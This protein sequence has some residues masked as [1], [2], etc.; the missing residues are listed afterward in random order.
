MSK[1]RFA[2]LG[3][4]FW[5]HFQ[6]PAWFEVGGVELVAAYNRTVAKAEAVAKKFGIPRVY[7]DPEE[8]LRNEKLDFID[9]ITEVPVHEPLVLLAAKYKVPV[10]CQKPMA[11]NY[12]SALRMVEACKSAGVP[13]FVHENYRWQAPMRRIKQMVNEGKI[14]RLYRG[15]FQFVHA[16]PEFAWQNQPLL[17]QLE[18]LIIADQGSHQLDLAR[19]FM[20]EAQSIYCQHLRLRHDIVG[21]DVAS[22]S[23]KMEQAIANVEL[24]FVTRTEGKHFPEATLFLE[25]TKGTLELRTDYWI[26]LTSDEGTLIDRCP[27]PR[28]AW[29]DPAYDINHASMVP[30][31]E[32]FLRA[33]RSGQAPENSGED[34]LKTM[35]LVYAAYESAQKN[36]V[37]NLR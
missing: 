22:I 8:L 3:T 36:Q 19:F 9:I 35:Q 17:K 7:G 26:H 34:N 15:R 1:L 16:L 33:L 24:T 32:D 18:K 23:L 31:H 6:I 20:G 27:P 29:A 28:Y 4:G 25:G 37:V 5:S 30:I 10:I 2:V 11:A 13:F 21:E 12:E 14:G